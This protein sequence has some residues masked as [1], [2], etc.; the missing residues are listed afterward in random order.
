[1]TFS[2]APYQQAI[3]KNEPISKRELG[4]Y[5][6]RLLHTVFEKIITAFAERAEKNGLTKARVAKLLG[7]DPGQLNRTLSMPSNMTLE[8]LADLAL[9]MGCEPDIELQKFEDAPRH[10]FVHSSMTSYT[11]ATSMRPAIGSSSFYT[12]N[13]S[14]LI[15]GENRNLTNIALPLKH[16]LE[17][18]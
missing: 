14:A 11:P 3:S 10:N 17:P 4:Y 1:V 2:Q 15:P 13:N 6:Q 9:A 16:N 7:K 12:D 8:M 5:R 18:A